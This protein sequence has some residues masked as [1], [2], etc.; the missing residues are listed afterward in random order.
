MNPLVAGHRFLL[1][2]A[3]A[4]GALLVALVACGPAPRARGDD[5]P[6]KADE[7]VDE[8]VARGLEWLAL[9]QA[10]DG[11]WGLNDFNRTARDRP[12]PAGKVFTCTCDAGT[13]RRSDIAGT[14]FGVLPFLAAG[15]T[16]KPGKGEK[17]Y[18]KTVAAGL[19]SLLT[20]QARDGSFT[21]EMY[22]HALAATAV[23]EAYGMTSDPALKASAQKAVD[24]ICSAQDPAGGGWRYAPRTAGDLSVTGFQFTA[25]KSA[26]MAGLAVPAATLK[27]TEKFLDSVAVEKGGYG[28]IP[29]GG[30]TPTMTAVGLQCRMYLGVN[31]RNPGLVAGVEKLKTFPPG[32]TGNLYY[33]YYATRVMYY[34]GG[35]NWDFWYR[36]PDGKGGIRDTLLA[37]QEHNAGAK[38]HVE[39]SWGPKTA[40]EGGRMM[41]TSLS[42]LCLETAY[43]RLPLFRRAADKLDP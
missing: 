14:A 33:E 41:A 26:Q 30:E 8:A 21:A 3:V 17:D 6:E 37:S 38:N 2:L 5:P 13:D 25:L 9:H 32:K 34:M 22:S 39:G 15:H 35:D 10:P 42:L 11:H 29:G 19:R 40:P 7:K 4:V 1:T 23:C 24:F 43:G 36:G 27:K 18:S 20:K 12:L 28:Y 31:P 16:H